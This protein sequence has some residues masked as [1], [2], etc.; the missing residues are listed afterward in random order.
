[1]APLGLSLPF[2]DFARDWEDI[3]W[4][5]EPVSR[6]IASLK[7]RGYTLILGSNTNV[8]HATHYRRQFAAT[9]DL[10]R[11]ISFSRTKSA[12]S[13]RTPGST[14]RASPRPASAAA[15]CV[16]VD[17][18]AE[19]VDGARKAGLI[20]VHYVDTPSLDRRPTTARSRGRA[21]VT[22]LEALIALQIRKASA[23]RAKSMHV[24][25]FHRIGTATQ[26][27]REKQVSPVL[28]V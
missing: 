7:S 25:R 13:S 16:F 9:L 8:L 18:L 17:D 4:L 3:F 19:N 22:S 21:G 6:L 26:R 28:P 20:G 23:S 15:S 27:G 12:A 14:R 24:S 11:R 10:V 1:M 5:N 2:D